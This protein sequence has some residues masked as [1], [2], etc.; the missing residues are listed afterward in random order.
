[1]AKIKQVPLLPL[2]DIIIFPYM[3]VPL[4]VGREKSINALDQ[5]MNDEKDILL[6][7]QINAKTNDPK[8]EDI[9]QTGCLGTIVQLLRLPDG[10]VKVLVEG[11]RR[12]RVLRYIGSDPFFVAEV[13]EIVEAGQL[14]PEQIVTPSVFVDMVIK[15]ERYDK[16]IEKRVNRQKSGAGV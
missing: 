5:A 11:T 13:E 2:R 12:A 7:A 9:Y 16:R 14:D 8:P 3:V 15:G 1:M 4:F 6:V 10:T